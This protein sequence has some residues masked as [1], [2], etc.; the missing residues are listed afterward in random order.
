MAAALA[1]PGR[2]LER[3]V[4]RLGPAARDDDLAGARVDRRG[5]SLMSL[6]ERG[7]GAATPGMGRRWVAELLAEERQHGLERFGP[8]RGR[9]RVIEVDRHRP[10]VGGAAV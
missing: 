10:I 1:R 7:A 4:E 5:D 8:Q 3:E 9:R 6:V 2:A